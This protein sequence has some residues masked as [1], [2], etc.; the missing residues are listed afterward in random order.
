MLFRGCSVLNALNLEKIKG[1]NSQFCPFTG[2]S[3]PFL[4]IPHT[5]PY[6]LEKAL[7]ILKGFLSGFSRAFQ[8]FPDF[9]V[10]I[11][12]KKRCFCISSTTKTIMPILLLKAAVMVARLVL[13]S[14]FRERSTTFC[15][16]TNEN[17]KLVNQVVSYLRIFSAQ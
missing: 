17:L 3:C 6:F 10:H 13:Y 2:R 14:L 4:V 7:N 16:K 1:K 12:F 8:G 15:I 5:C 11:F 9:Q